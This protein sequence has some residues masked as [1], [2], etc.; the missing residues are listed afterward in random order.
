MREKRKKKLNWGVAG[1]GRITEFSFVPTVS[2]LT[3]SYISAV[4]SHSLQ[5]AQSIAAKT[6]SAKAFNNFDEFIS[7]DFDAVYI[8]GANDTHYEQVIKAAKA[9]KH[10]LC[11]KPVAMTSL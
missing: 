6:V 5:R 9:G 1:C 2:L 8:A 3:K 10:I 4:Y 11:E 7:R